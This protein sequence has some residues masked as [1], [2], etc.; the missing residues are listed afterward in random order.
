MSEVLSRRALNRALLARQHLLARAALLPLELIEQLLGLQAQAPNPPYLGLWTRLERFELPQLTALLESGAVVRA[1]SLRSTLHLWSARDYLAWRATLGPMMARRSHASWG[2]TLGGAA[3]AAIT[4]A[5]LALLAKE[6]LTAKALGEAL[7]PRFPGAPPQG[8][9]STV[10]DHAPLIQLPP[11]GT[12]DHHQQPR[13]R[14]ARQH[15]GQAPK[16][17]RP[18]DG[19]LLRALAATGPSSAAD[20]R[21]FTGLDAIAPALERLRRQLVTFR[22]EAGATLYDLPDAPR[23]PEDVPAPLRL[24]P[25]WD[26]ALLA[27]ADRTRILPEAAYRRVFSENGLV[28]PTV[29]VDGEVRATFT[30]ERKQQTASLTVTPLAPLPRAVRPALEAEALG[31]LSA[32]A[33]GARASVRVMQHG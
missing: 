4:R 7:A 10:R 21:V 26:N 23:P 14:P 6:A 19:L 13:L 30:V 33:P 25:E 31:W 20:L 8:L 12:F 17:A 32:V 22:D 16:P 24:L 3:P 1:A 15:L 5:G 11:A 27:H 2:R 29:L 28:R 18:I 9:A